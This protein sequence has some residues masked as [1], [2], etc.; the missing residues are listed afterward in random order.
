[1]SVRYDFISKPNFAL[2]ALFCDA[3]VFSG[4]LNLE[5]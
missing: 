4:V 2:E 5:S 3:R 1:M